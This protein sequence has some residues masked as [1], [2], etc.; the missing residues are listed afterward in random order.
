MNFIIMKVCQRRESGYRISFGTGKKC[1]FS[2]VEIIRDI[3]K[4]ATSKFM[5]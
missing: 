1:S 3:L 5:T 2:F 4:H